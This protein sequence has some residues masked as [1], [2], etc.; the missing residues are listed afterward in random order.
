MC[1]QLDRTFAFIEK[2]APAGVLV[3]LA[4]LKDARSQLFDVDPGKRQVVAVC[5]SMGVDVGSLLIFPS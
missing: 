2:A 5:R 4:R 1:D 3:K